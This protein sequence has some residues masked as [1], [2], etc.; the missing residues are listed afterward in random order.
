[1]LGR[2]ALAR[3]QYREAVSHFEG[4]SAKGRVTPELEKGLATALVNLG[5][6][7]EACS[8]MERALSRDPSQIEL[9]YQL[10]GSYLARG[11]FT[12]ALPHLEQVY[13]EGLRH[14][15][16]LMQLARARLKVGQDD[17]AVE[18]LESLTQNSSAT[19][20][21]MEVGK[22]LF[23]RLLY[24]Q[25]LPPLRKAWQQKPGSYD[26][27]MYLAL[28]HYQLKQ[29]AESE[30]I[31]AAIQ[32]GTTPPLD[33]R[34]LLGSVYARLG[35]WE[36]S[37]RE[38]EKAILQAPDRADGY[39]NLGL[40][41]L[42]RG[43][44]QRAME[45]LEKGSRMMVPGTKL[46]YS[47][48]TRENCNDLAPPQTIV[49][50]DNIRG[51]F[52]S[53]LA[54]ALQK[55]EHWV[56]ALEVYWL[57]LQVDNQSAAAY[58]GIGLMCQ[59]LG[60][61]EVSRAFLQK[62]LELH[63]GTADLHYYLGAIYYELGSFDKAILSYQKAIELQAPNVPSLYLV[64]LGIAQ[65]AGAKEAEAQ[66]EASF[67]RALELDPDF[68]QAHYELGK[69]YLKRKELERAEQSFE[70]AIQLDPKLLGAY[71]QCGLTCIRQGKSEKGK[72]LLET[73][74]RRRTLHAPR[75]DGMAAHSP[76]PSQVSP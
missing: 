62:G 25:A 29:Y 3:Q 39:L 24:A 23:E 11:K 14:A 52:Y 55:A 69:L 27:G 12:E 63:P 76:A 7:Q 67:L 4:A 21:L 36:E 43:N 19:G 51:E 53:N 65:L 75:S 33:Y 32:P 5:R 56:S 72:S 34:I 31:L 41:H 40:F 48:H 47:L 42:E 57:A 54:R 9:R 73:F 18:L 44:Q 1:L 61:V 50:R 22:L 15:G 8:V 30:G 46:L 68:A 58:G 37:H 6:H 2:I 64:Q 20:L 66:A 35:R 60:S 26:I 17:R 13:R 70:R 16:V 10:A 71:Y 38:L 59:E 74:N 28:S 49:K 45:L